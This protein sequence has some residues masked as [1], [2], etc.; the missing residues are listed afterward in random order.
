MSWP[1]L[2]YFICPTALVRANA[3]YFR[4]HPWL[5]LVAIIGIALGVSGVAGVEISNYS[6]K[7]NFE[8]ASEQL[9]GRASHRIS[10]QQPIPE[11]LLTQL[12]VDW[13]IEA[14]PLISR[15]LRLNNEKGP[16]F[17]LL[18]VDPFLFQ[19]FHPSQ[20]QQLPAGF[21]TEQLLLKP[22]SVLM[23]ESSYRRH[24]MQ[25]DQIDLYTEVGIRTVQIIARVGEADDSHFSSLLLMDIGRAQQLLDL[26][27]Q[28]DHI[29]LMISEEQAQAI[30]DWL[31]A[32][33][34]IYPAS[35][36]RQAT[37][38]LGEALHLN[39]SAMGMLAM[40][41]GVF[42]V[43]NT[44][45]FSLVQR[46]QLFG[47]LRSIGVTQ[48]ELLRYL[49]LE[50]LVIGT[51]GTLLGLLAGLLLADKLILLVTR[52]INDLYAVSPIE[53]IQLRPQLLLK[54]VLVG[55]GG[56]MLAGLLPALSSARLSI[57]QGASRQQLETRG[58][59][60]SR[61][62]PLLALLLV[63]VFGL[64][65]LWRESGIIGGYLAVTA[66]ILGCALLM[67][68]FVRVGCRCLHQGINRLRPQGGLLLRMALKDTQ[69]GLSRTA[70]ALMAL[71]VA[72]SVTVS[73]TLMIGSFRST[74]E[75]WLNQRLNADVYISPASRL[76]GDQGSLPVTVWQWLEQ[77]PEIHKLASYRRISVLSEQGK[78]Q[79]FASQLPEKGR[80][81]Y[82]FLSG[83]PAAI[84][85]SFE[86]KD[87]ILI[88][89]PL[90]NRLGLDRGDDLSLPTP[91]GRQVFQ[92]AGVYYDYGDSNG[93]AILS[94][95][96]FSRYWQL[97]PARVAGI[98][99][100]DPEQSDQFLNRLYQLPES[101]ELLVSPRNGVLERSLQIFER[102]FLVTDALR[103][104]AL[105]VAFVGVFA[106]LMALQLERR[107]ELKLYKAVGLTLSQ[108]VRLLLYQGLL[109][110]L[111]AGFA[112]IP[113]GVLLSWGLIELI[114]LRAFGWT[115]F[116]QWQ[117]LPLLQTPMLALT[118]A[119]LAGAY[120]A[121][122]QVR[123]DRQLQ[124]RWRSAGRTG[125]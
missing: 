64:F 27:R 46:Q 63:V 113:V 16:I 59:Q 124:M 33:V 79:L 32:G 13:G 104:L 25:G 88:S 37:Q 115:L 123:E 44:L 122:L 10:S 78:I 93:R 61:K 58:T 2:L 73:M 98:Y 97:T 116:Y 92:V 102:T 29:E 48:R 86:Q 4:Q 99:L 36:Q 111:L 57:R 71:M 26:P 24:Q 3:G 75:L 68:L 77:Q 47:Q 81:G 87:Q 66:L 42:L 82:R 60:L 14:A 23:A 74:L 94:P 95:D 7:K 22:A 20:N 40:V 121:W 89:E 112:A 18:A 39:L 34:Q 50:L 105:L 67:P 84:W 28:L 21:D 35:R 119:L 117:W 80:A 103:L 5:L 41:V 120:P 62:L 91:S 101:D 106:A 56:A 125:L 110:G 55:I 85:K 6:A 107:Q 49:L 45:F 17:Q 43:Y 118:A 53:L 100:H 96:N 65:Y 11:S 15:Y 52:T 90:A 54:I 51:L 69:R 9:L 8:I 114:Q 70:V 109:I 31:P 19:R 83:D 72:V 38:N 1:R 30:A 108:R 76:P 12:R